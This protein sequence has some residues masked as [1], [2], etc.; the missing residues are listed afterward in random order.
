MAFA[1][2]QWQGTGNKNQLVLGPNGQQAVVSVEDFK[3]VS[4]LKLP[5]P[6]SASSS[7]I[8]ADSASGSQTIKGNLVVTGTVTDA[9]GGGNTPSVL[10]GNLVFDNKADREVTFN[11]SNPAAGVKLSI[12]GNDG[13]AGNGGAL[14]LEA[15]SGTATGGKL[16]LEA[17]AGAG[18]NGAIE[19]G[20]TT[21]PSSITVGN[22]SMANNV[23]INKST[24]IVGDLLFDNAAARSIKFDANNAGAGSKLSITG[25]GGSAGNGGDVAVTA[26]SGSATG[27]K[28]TLEAGAGTGGNGAIELGVTTPAS[29]LTIGN[30]SMT[31]N[32]KLNKNLEILPTTNQIT[33]G[34][35]N[36]TTLNA[37]A[38]ASSIVSNLPTVTGSIASTTG[39]NLWYGDITRSTSDVNCNTA[40]L[41]NVPNLKQT[42]VAGATYSYVC[43][44]HSLVNIDTDGIQ[45]AFNL[46]NGATLTANRET[47]VAYADG[48]GAAV[49]VD[50]D[51]KLGPVI[52]LISVADAIAFTQVA[53]TMVV[54]AGGTLDMQVAKSTGG[55]TATI[56]YAGSS[57]QFVRIA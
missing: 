37:A 7:F 16:T 32:I 31:N 52:N 10:D 44:M 12:L 45:Y 28:L 50:H 1:A 33:L 43:Y 20:V 54:N 6:G 24:E 18:S 4:V 39:P 56:C 53:G 21:A 55:G 11:A 15:G 19:L 48:P 30:A 57:M 22:S 42:L 34:T 35:T 47:T 40:T 13:L 26:G 2:L 17:G 49:H 46:T 25:N 14:N 38:P 23:V 41:T 29:N 8:L 51:N 36:T 27:G 9:G 5:D 3:Q